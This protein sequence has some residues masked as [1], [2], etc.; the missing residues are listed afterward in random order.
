[1]EVRLTVSFPSL[2]VVSDRTLSTALRL[3]SR[4]VRRVREAELVWIL[5]RSGLSRR[6]RQSIRDRL[7]R[8]LDG[9][10]TFYVERIER[11]SL[12]LEVL[13]AATAIWLLKETIGESIRE[14]WKRTRTHRW[15][16]HVLSNSPFDSAEEADEQEAEDAGEGGV[17]WQFMAGRL[18]GEFDVGVP[19][20]RFEVVDFR[21]SGLENGDM[22]VEVTL[23]LSE[24]YEGDI[25]TRRL[26]A[27]NVL[28]ELR[29]E[30]E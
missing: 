18:A 5:N 29:A 15:L 11:G 20:G 25:E 7:N 4:S 22:L 27:E 28:G 17:R 2:E 14:G 16:V 9:A 26:D 1:M 8:H 21:I 23:E 12:G 30:L 3:I 10:A 19:F 24:E 6:E 13:L